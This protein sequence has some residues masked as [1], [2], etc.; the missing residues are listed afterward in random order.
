M[1]MKTIKIILIITGFTLLSISCTK[2]LEE[3]GYNIDY[4]YYET[5]DGVNSLVVACY[6]QTRWAANAENQYALEDMGTDL[7]MLGGDG[8]YRDAFGQYLTNSLSPNNGVTRSFWE[9]NYKGISICNLAV[10][11]VSKNAEM[12]SEVKNARLGEAL[13]LR[14]YYY[15]EL[16]IQF[17]DVVLSNKFAFYPKLD[18][19]R[20]PQKQVWSQIITDLRQ[21]WIF[22]PGLMALEK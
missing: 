6:Q 17:G 11:Y 14:A 1:K 10:E 13:F 16:V 5:L 12:T 2:F 4:S 19:V 21:A 8:P 22:F 20:V 3:E 9:N 7:Y 18:Y 15:Y